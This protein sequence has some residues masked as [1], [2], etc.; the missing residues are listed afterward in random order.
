MKLP[1]FAVVGGL[2]AQAIAA[3]AP[4]SHAV[5]ERRDISSSKWTRS[6]IKLR[7]DAVMPMSI[8]LKQ[9]NL[10]NGYEYLMEVSDPKSPN[11]GKHWTKEK[12]CHL[13]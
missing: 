9:R 11:F 6:D 10:D 2:L 3:P 8:G 4:I 1:L 7:Q 13:L 5:H 12:V